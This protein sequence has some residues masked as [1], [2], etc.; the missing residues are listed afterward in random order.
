MLRVEPG[1]QASAC[2]NGGSECRDEAEAVDTTS[3]KV[4]NPSLSNIELDAA[5][6]R[7]NQLITTLQLRLPNAGE[8]HGIKLADL[9]QMGVSALARSLLASAALH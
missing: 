8:L 4:T 2:L 9:L 1:L 3:S 7:R 6:S 5:V